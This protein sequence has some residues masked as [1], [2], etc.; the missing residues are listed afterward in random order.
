[1]PS[2]DV[3]SKVDLMEL[4]NALN[5]TQK[6]IVNRYDFRG[7][8]TSLE[9][10]DN[11]V[12]VRTADEP[13]LEAVVQLFRER[14]VKRGVSGRCLDPQKVEPATHKSVR[15]SLLIKQGIETDV[16]KT[17]TK[18]IKDKKFKVTAQ[19]QGDEVR[20]TGKK[21]DDLQAVIAFLKA[22]DFGVDLQ[23]ENFRD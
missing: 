5:V 13:H 18:A 12:V 19:I 16:A 2:F 20:V 8:E 7:T 14:L 17:I 15:Q 10:K 6:E 23:F 21:R 9:R 3:V 1:M 22:E 4:D 11:T